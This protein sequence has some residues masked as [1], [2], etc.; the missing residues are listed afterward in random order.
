MKLYNNTNA[1]LF[2]KTVN[3]ILHKQSCQSVSPSFG[4]LQ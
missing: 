3:T 2:C 4:L 1:V